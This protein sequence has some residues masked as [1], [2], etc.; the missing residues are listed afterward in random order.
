MAQSHKDEKL[1]QSGI[2]TYRTDMPARCD[3]T[4]LIL[5]P[6]EYDEQ[7]EEWRRGHASDMAHYA[8]E[9]SSFDPT[10]K[11]LCGGEEGNGEEGCNQYRPASHQC[12]SVAGRIDG[13][14]GSCSWW[15]QYR[16][17]HADL[18]MGPEKFTKGA[19]MYG[20]REPGGTGFGCQ[21][22]EYGTPARETDQAGRSIYCGMWGTRV[23]ALACCGRNHKLGDKNFKDNQPLT[24]IEFYTG[25]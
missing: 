14:C 1:I 25:Q 13:D 5:E 11:Y 12:L 22:C 17:E 16:K 2:L 6:K 19:A 7:V 10:G 20:E 8:E 21:R 9:G 15:E 3:D 23:Q 4:G 18:Y 24:Q